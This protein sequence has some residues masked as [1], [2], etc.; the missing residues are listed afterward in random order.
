MVEQTIESKTYPKFLF[1]STSRSQDIL[2]IWTLKDHY[3]VIP[4]VTLLTKNLEN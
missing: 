1:N 4:K 3:A 2:L